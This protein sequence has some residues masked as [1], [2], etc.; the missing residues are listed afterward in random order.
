MDAKKELTKVIFFNNRRICD[1][2]NTVDTSFVWRNKKLCPLAG[3]TWVSVLGVVFGFLLL[4]T[5]AD[6]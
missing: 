1:W 6:D 2:R 4:A 5:C 3:R